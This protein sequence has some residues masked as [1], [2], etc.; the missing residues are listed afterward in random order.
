ME[1]EYLSKDELAQKVDVTVRTIESW[2]KHR[3]VPYEKIGRTVRFCWPVVKSYWAEHCRVAPVTDPRELRMRKG[4][5]LRGLA[6][7][8]RREQ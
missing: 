4:S 8:I 5:K 1:R 3:L 2:M 6:D 7:A